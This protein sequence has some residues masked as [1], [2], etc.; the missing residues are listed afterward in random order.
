[1]YRIYRLWIPLSPLASTHFSSP[2][3]FALICLCVKIIVITILKKK[4]RKTRS[5]DFFF[6]STIATS[7]PSFFNPCTR[8][9]ISSHLISFRHISVYVIIQIN[10][11]I[12]VYV[13]YDNSCTKIFYVKSTIVIE[14]FRHKAIAYPLILDDA[15]QLGTNSVPGTI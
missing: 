1:M 13:I 6:F 11:Y 15:D 14:T 12:Y 2:P 5:F 8:D 4:K 7:S 10:I 9:L 3:P